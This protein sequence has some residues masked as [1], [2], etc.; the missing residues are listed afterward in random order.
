M[1]TRLLCRISILS[2]SLALCLSQANAQQQAETPSEEVVPPTDAAE[3]QSDEPADSAMEENNESEPDADVTDTPSPGE[4]AFQRATQHEKDDQLDEA[5][6]DCT[7]AIQLDPDNLDYLTTR[8]ELYGEMRNQDKAME[9]AAKIL[10]KDPTNLRA[11]L[12]RGKMFELA[13]NSEKALVEFNAAVER[14]PTNWQALAARRDYFERQGET[15]KA[16]A[17]S[18]RVIQLEPDLS[19]GYLERAGSQGAAGNSD[20]TIKY[21]ELVINRNPE[22][23]L[24]YN[25]RAAARAMKHEYA[26]AK[27]DYDMALKLSP[28]NVNVLAAR[29][30][31]YAV[32]GDY[33]KSLADLQKADALEP[34]NY[35]VKAELADSLATCPDD[36]LRDGNKA[37]EYSAQALKLA[38]NDPF[39]WRASAS[40]AA[41]NGDFQAA[42]KWQQ[43]LLASK[44]LS[45]DQRRS[46]EYRLEAYN[47]AKPYRENFPT[48]ERALV[49]NKV[50]AGEEAIKNGNFDRAIAVLSE[51]IAT[52]PKDWVPYYGRG[53]AYSRQNKYE[54]ALTD[55]NTAIRLNPKEADC[56]DARAHVLEKTGEYKKA[57]DDFETVGKLDPSDK[58]G[59]RNNLAWLFATCP[60]DSIR[61][62]AKASEYVDRALEVQSNYAPVWDT[63]AAVFAENGDFDDAIEWEKAFLERNDITEENRRGGKNRLAL[64]EQHRAFRNEPEEA[65]NPLTASTI[66]APPEK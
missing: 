2:I 31:F 65:T 5:I 7:E 35:F 60:D 14:N 50:K 38:P 43:Q 21:S 36:K 42:I 53:I 22:N 18:D 40:V 55:F 23:W 51:A 16:I 13:G 33:E 32:T 39:V 34:R 11:Q 64:Y 48:P 3:I 56:Y 66:P 45:R 9:D 47:S 20:E 12:L 4:E 27:E 1:N 17:D 54:P 59:T 26:E 29:S 30:A 52:D 41:E 6:T 61:D 63:C 8:A 37:A 10:E 62:G 25:L 15:D 57:V 58:S 44:S 19:A 28:D 24:A 46:A 49:L